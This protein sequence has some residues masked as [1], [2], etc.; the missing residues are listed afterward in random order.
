MRRLPA[1]TAVPSEQGKGVMTGGPTDHRSDCQS[2]SA[3]PSAE[4]SR[5]HR[6]VAAREAE[7]SWVRASHA[8][9]SRRSLTGPAPVSLIHLRI[10]SA[11]TGMVPGARV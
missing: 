2:T 11:S 1:S 9:F 7:V 8:S 10:R 6:P 5:S 4:I 3:C